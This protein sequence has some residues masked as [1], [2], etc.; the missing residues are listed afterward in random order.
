[1]ADEQKTNLRLEIAHVL[2]IDIVGYSKLTTDEQSETLLELNAI[3]RRTETAQTAEAAG[4]LVFLPTGDGMAMVFTGSE[5]EPVECA[6]EIAQTLRAKQRLPV[7][8]TAAAI[9]RVRKTVTQNVLRHQG[10]TIRQRQQK[11]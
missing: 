10:R 1:M 11:Q 4:Q 7:Q 5:E 2:F 8:K 3:V 9:N 6:L